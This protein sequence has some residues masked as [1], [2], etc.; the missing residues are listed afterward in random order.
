MGAAG[1]KA[2]Q[3][4]GYIGSEAF[5]TNSC[6]SKS[7]LGLSVGAEQWTQVPVGNKQAAQTAP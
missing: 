1:L 6:W 3:R 4:I 2:T 7:A 5:N